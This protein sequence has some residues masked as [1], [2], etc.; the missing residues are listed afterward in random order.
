[1]VK[2][3]ST[4]QSIPLIYIMHSCPYLFVYRYGS[5]LCRSTAY[6]RQLLPIMKYSSFMGPGRPVNQLTN[7]GT[8]RSTSLVVLSNCSS[9]CDGVSP[10]SFLYGML[11]PSY[12]MGVEIYVHAHI[13]QLFASIYISIY[14]SM[15]L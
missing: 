10:L 5:S 15:Y 9:C 7:Y 13:S 3:I 4:Q 6:R 8:S 14:L 1:M 12:N 2:D 11:K